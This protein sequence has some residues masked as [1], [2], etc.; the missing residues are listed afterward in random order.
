MPLWI[1][2]GGAIATGPVGTHV[3]AVPTGPVELRTVAPADGR[4][5]EGLFVTDGVEVTWRWQNGELEL[6][7]P[8]EVRRL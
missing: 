7:P 5:A 8:I 4:P 2:D 3:G 1:R 6:D